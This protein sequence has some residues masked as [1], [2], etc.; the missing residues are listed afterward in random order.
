MKSTD[1]TRHRK[2][3]FPDTVIMV[4]NKT[5][6]GIRSGIRAFMD[7]MKAKAIQIRRFQREECV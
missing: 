2:I 7:T 6:K 3:S 1:F 4:L 5:G